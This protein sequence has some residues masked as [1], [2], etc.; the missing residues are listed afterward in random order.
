MD[1]V[2]NLD[3]ATTALRE[4]VRSLQHDNLPNTS[5]KTNRKRPSPTADGGK[6]KRNRITFE[7]SQID[8]LEKVFANNQYPDAT[9]R[10]QL[11]KKVQLQEERVQIWFQNRRAKFRREMKNKNDSIEPSTKPATP[12]MEE[13][14]LDEILNLNKTIVE[15]QKPIQAAVPVIDNTRAFEAKTVFNADQDLSAALCILLNQAGANPTYSEND[16]IEEDKYESQ[17]SAENTNLL[18]LTLSHLFTTQHES[19]LS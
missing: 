4:I 19:I 2:K 17:L 10:E 13:K 8:E 14:K 3:Y 18:M 11:A 6:K 7:A 9:V 16:D 5:D 1:I 15:C 12:S